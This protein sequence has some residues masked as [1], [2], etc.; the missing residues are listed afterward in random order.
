[1]EGE[2]KAKKPKLKSSK[3]LLCVLTNRG[4]CCNMSLPRRQNS[5]VEKKS[6]RNI[7]FLCFFF[8]CVSFQDQMTSAAEA[9]EGKKE[10][11]KKEKLARLF[12]LIAFEVEAISF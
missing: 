2:K 12:F 10:R 5:L 8:F 1:M 6:A 4:N 9:V 11:K 7:F 3:R